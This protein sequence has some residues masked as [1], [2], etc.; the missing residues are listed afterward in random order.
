MS[1]PPVHNLNTIIQYV[2]EKDKTAGR[3]G[4]RRRA[5][6]PCGAGVPGRAAHLAR[7][8]L[9]KIDVNTKHRRSVYHEQETRTDRC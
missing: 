1:S 9:M 7:G 2:R 3:N 5:E 8:L 4:G 6:V